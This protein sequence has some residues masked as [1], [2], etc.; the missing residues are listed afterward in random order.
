MIFNLLS[1][2]F[3]PVVLRSGARSW[4]A[5]PDLVQGATVSDP[6][7]DY[8]VDFDWPRPD[9]NMASFELCIGLISLAFDIR[10][11]D[12]WRLLWGNPPERS[13]FASKLAPFAHAFRLEG[14][15]PRFLQD[16]EHFEDSV[17]PGEIKPVEALLIDTPGEQARKQNKDVL[18][19]RA[20]YDRL[21]LPAA[22]MALYTL[23]AYAP[24]GGAGNRTSMRGGGPL[25]A[26]VIPVP[27]DDEPPV[28]LWRK[29]VANV[30]ACRDRLRPNAFPKALPW[31]A[32]TIT[33]DRKGGGR[34]VSE[35]DSDVHALQAY[36]GMPRR[37]RLVFSG[38][39]G[40]CPMTGW[41]GRV[42]TGFV[43]R[44]YG[45][46]YGLW[47]HPLTPY[48]RRKEDADPYSVKPKSGRFGYR[49]WIGVTVGSKEGIV[50]DP[51]ENIRCARQSRPNF[52]RQEKQGSDARIRVG[53]WA[54]RNMEAIAYLFAEQPMHM[55]KTPDQQSELDKFARILADT[56]DQVAALLQSGLKQGL[57]KGRKSV[58]KDKGVIDQA[59][60]S[61]FDATEDAFHGF[62]DDLLREMPEN[63]CLPDPAKYTR[64]WLNIMRRTALS[65]FDQLA[66]VSMQD[67]EKAESVVAGYG[68]LSATL[69]G[70]TKQS[71][72]LFSKLE[73]P[74]PE[75]KKKEAA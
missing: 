20:R 1:D 36:F 25:T 35:R 63:G 40:I 11:E 47:K 13:A 4:L 12:D 62:L 3:F 75:R 19:H 56:A 15:G 2:L 44:P 70:W 74:L 55:T 5:A 61:F 18:T 28:P 59:G 26:L 46:N 17:K 16:Y 68:R 30:V 52:L 42:V 73:L 45:V 32:P 41:Q 27:V 39:S 71:K 65:I 31:L 10:D 50:A 48:R 29:I 38:E 22:A 60:M 64:R 67:A 34:T 43:Q 6:D 69:S 54:M 9:F 8:P 58:P 51:P 72:P 21:G 33:S 7:E 24:S 49:D 53:G 57:L 14:D 66:P 23:Q 37:I